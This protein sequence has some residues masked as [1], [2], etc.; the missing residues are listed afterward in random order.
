MTQTTTIPKPSIMAA[1]RKTFAVDAKDQ[2]LGRL[3]SHL[4]I[5]LRGKHKPSF[6]P[7]VDCGDCVVVSNVAKIRLTGNKINQKEYFRH[8]GYARGARV[9]PIKRQM[10]ND[11]T[12]V[13]YLAVKRMLDD[14]THRSRQLKRLRM[15]PGAAPAGISGLPLPVR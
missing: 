5:V 10:E 2:V 12:R 4:A 1:S 14:N 9:I 11:P 7:T 8:S 3:A 15:F 13:L 6:T